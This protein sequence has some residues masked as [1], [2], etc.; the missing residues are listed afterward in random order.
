[1]VAQAEEYRTNYDLEIKDIELRL[2]AMAK[3][4]R[5]ARPRNVYQAPKTTHK[6]VRKV[7]KKKYSSPPKKAINADA[8]A[9]KQTSNCLF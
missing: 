9:I 5:S 8:C 3:S 6:P 4:A 2:A 1:V 7:R